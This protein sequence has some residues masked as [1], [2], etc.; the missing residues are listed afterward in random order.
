MDLKVY[1]KKLYLKYSNFPFLFYFFHSN[2]DVIAATSEGVVQ[3]ID[4]AFKEIS[5]PEW[6]DH[7]IVGGADGAFVNFGRKAGIMTLIKNDCP[8]LIDI[9]CVAHRLELALRDSLKGTHWIEVSINSLFRIFYSDKHT[10]YYIQL[11]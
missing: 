9:H 11:V 2:V 4:S 10:I 7:L 8:W 5:F 6:K 1:I 3:A